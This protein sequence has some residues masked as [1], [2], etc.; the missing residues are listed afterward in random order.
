M[1]VT[2]PLHE[3]SSRPEH[4]TRFEWVAPRGWENCGVRLL[5]R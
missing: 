1:E 2:R 4:S 5:V 3:T